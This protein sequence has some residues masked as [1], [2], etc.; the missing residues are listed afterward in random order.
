[1]QS[2][3]PAVN[4]IYVTLDLMVIVINLLPVMLLR[5]VFP[6]SRSYATVTN[7]GVSRLSSL[8][9]GDV[10]PFS[11]FLTD[12]FG[13]QHN[14]LRISLTER[15]NLRCLL[16]LCFFSYFIG[17]V[18]LHLFYVT[19]KGQYCMP[20]EGVEL[21]PKNQLLSSTEIVDI[22]AIF[23]QQGVDKIRLTGGEP[24][25]R[26]ELND[27][28]G[29]RTNN[30]I[31]NL[32]HHNPQSDNLVIILGSLKNLPGMKTIAITTNGLLLTRKLPQL[33]DSGLD[34][35]NIS[36][37][38]LV[39]AK[40]EFLTRRK[41]LEKVLQGIDLAIDLGYKPKVMYFDHLAKLLALNVL[42]HRSTV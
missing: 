41:G 11:A 9:S 1:M 24:T 42:I 8:R 19:F 33:K 12:T 38:T 29:T 39:P 26:P 30:H 35:L 16:L 6:F 3:V 31:L 32:V 22:A 14:Y 40:F 15:C 7:V 4:Y 5:R 18:F 20:A 28:V 27:I 23:A 13:R 2:V 37:D 25:V 34:L 10:L 17:N 36:L 21:T